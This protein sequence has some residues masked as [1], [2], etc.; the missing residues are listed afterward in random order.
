LPYIEYD[1]LFWEVAAYDGATAIESIPA[2]LGVVRI[3]TSMLK[4]GMMA[5]PPQIEVSSLS[6]SG[7]MVL[8]K[9]STDPNVQLMIEGVAIKLDNDGKFIHTIS[10]SS[11]GIKEIVFRAVAL[12][13]LTTVI[14]KQVTIF[15]E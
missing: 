9:G 1:R 6:V 11:I 2:R 15:E 10:Y 4:K 14:K 13:G 8:I 3:N 12:S 5:P 7:N